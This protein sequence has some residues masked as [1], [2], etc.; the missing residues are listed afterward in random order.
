MKKKVSR[1]IL[2]FRTLIKQP[3]FWNLTAA[4][5]A[6]IV[7]G[8]VFL[9][10]FESGT[11]HPPLDF[12]DCLLW[13]TGTVTTV[14]YGSFTAYSLPGKIVLFFLMLLGT[15][16]VWSYMDFLVTGLIAPELSLLEKEVRDVEKEIK[17]LKTPEA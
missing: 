10:R 17:E 2:R 6:I 9:Y 3:F 7:A 12:L 11:Q 15:L 4:G 8:S 13:S 16:F 5:N 14:G 1:P